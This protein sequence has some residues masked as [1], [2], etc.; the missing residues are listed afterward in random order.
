MKKAIYPGSFDPITLGHL[1]IVK[2]ACKLFDEVDIVILNN[3]NKHYFF[4]AN[5]RKEL[6]EGALIEQEI[7]NCRVVVYDQLLVE[8]AKK[9]GITNVI[10]GLRMVTDFEYEFQ[11]NAINKKLF[12]EIETHFFMTDEKYSFLSSSTVREIAHFKGDISQFVTKNVELCFNN[13]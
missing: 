10:R 11:L 2:R 9:T 4:E 3:P 13:L 7:K 1:N 12:P 8:Y 5:T 6:I